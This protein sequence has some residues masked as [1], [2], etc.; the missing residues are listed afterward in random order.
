MSMGD[1][2]DAMLREVGK[3]ADAMAVVVAHV[4]ALNVVP[5]PHLSA[6]EQALRKAGD[7]LTLAAL[8]LRHRLQEHSSRSML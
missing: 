7:E 8:E 2:L 6:A 5:I 1:H 4:A 3:N